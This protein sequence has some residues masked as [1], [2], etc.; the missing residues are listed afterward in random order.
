MDEMA[1]ARRPRALGETIQVSRLGGDAYD[2]TTTVQRAAGT[3]E[4]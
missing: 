2:S 4:R 1:M 3:I